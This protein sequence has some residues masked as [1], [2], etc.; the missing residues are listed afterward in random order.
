MRRSLMSL[1]PSASFNIITFNNVSILVDAL[2][3]PSL[4]VFVW[5]L[6]SMWKH[7]TVTSTAENVQDA[8]TWLSQVKTSGPTHTLG[9]TQYT[10]PCNTII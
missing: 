8:I 2:L 6:V 5:Q 9:P 1:S 10:L 4:M 3:I 7:D